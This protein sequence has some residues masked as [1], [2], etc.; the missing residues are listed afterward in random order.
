MDRRATWTRMKPQG[1]LTPICLIESISTI[2]QQSLQ[3]TCLA[4]GRQEECKRARLESY[5]R[6]CQSHNRLGQ[7]MTAGNAFIVRHVERVRLR[8]KHLGRQTKLALTQHGHPW[9]RK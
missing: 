2:I 8:L 6:L 5:G 4:S 3:C 1:L 7:N 9:V